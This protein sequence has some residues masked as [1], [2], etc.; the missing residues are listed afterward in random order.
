MSSPL[1][2]GVINIHCQFCVVPRILC[3]IKLEKA[4]P[5]VCVQQINTV[6]HQ[7]CLQYFPIILLYLLISSLWHTRSDLD[8]SVLETNEAALQFPCSFMQNTPKYYIQNTLQ[9]SVVFPVWFFS[10]FLVFLGENKNR[11]WGQKLTVS[12]FVGLW[13]D[14][15]VILGHG[16]GKGSGK[17]MVCQDGRRNSVGALFYRIRFECWSLTHICKEWIIRVMT[18]RFPVWWWRED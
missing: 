11:K 16:K 3:P 12:R 14:F 1:I 6:S 17:W 9:I 7:K 15:H 18:P 4:S 13:C 5:A 8:F 2:S 10:S